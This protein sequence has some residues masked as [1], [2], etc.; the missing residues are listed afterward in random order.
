VR[1]IRREEGLKKA[2]RVL[3][4]WRAYWDDVDPYREDGEIARRLL[5]TR[6]P[7]SGPCCGNPRRWWR[8]T[9][10][11]E[12]KADEEFEAELGALE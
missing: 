1:G 6:V 7:C 2:R 9:T 8:E 12:R 11:Q 5:H 4:A 3:R 10:I